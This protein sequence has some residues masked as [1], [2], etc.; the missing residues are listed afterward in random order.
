MDGL[1]NVSSEH[2]IKQVQNSTQRRRTIEMTMSPRTVHGAQRAPLFVE[3]CQS[4]SP[5]SSAHPKL[6]QLIRDL[7]KCP[8][9]AGSFRERSH[10]HFGPPDSFDWFAM[11]V[12]KTRLIMAVN[13][14]TMFNAG[15]DVSFNGSPTVS[16]VTEFA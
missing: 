5:T 2:D 11:A 10:N 9:H 7:S 14:M 8:A 16:P 1:S 15:P 4:T 13:F 6:R 3:A 12:P